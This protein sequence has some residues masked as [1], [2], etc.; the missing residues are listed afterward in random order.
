M[1]LRFGIDVGGT[2]TDVVC[3]R[4]DDQ[5]RG[6][7]DTTHYDLKV[8]FF[9]AARLAA[10][11]AG[12]GL[13]EALLTADAIVYSTTVGTNALIERRGSRLGLI[14]TKGFEHTVKV[15]RARNWGDGLPTDLPAGLAAEALVERM[16]LD[17]KAVSG[18]LRLVLWRGPGRAEVAPDVAEDAIAAVLR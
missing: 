7:A 13:E 11:K 17:K 8:G 9:N 1:T 2:F 3:I 10:E 4:D 15:G 16:R 14:T 18:R 5:F 6:K 12:L